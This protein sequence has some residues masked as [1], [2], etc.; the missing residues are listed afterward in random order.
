LAILFA[1]YNIYF[2]G[3]WGQT[4]GKMAMK[5]RVVT[6]AGQPAG[7]TRAL[8][9][10][11]VDLVFSIIQTALSFSEYLSVTSVEYDMLDFRG[12]MLLVHQHEHPATSTIE[13][14]NGLWITSELI[15]LLFNEKRRALHDFLGGT[16]VIHTE[17]KH[18]AA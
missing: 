4:V 16:V 10:H 14:L 6:V 2:I 1:S 3:R 18:V 11:S 7:F 9:R 5:I 17:A 8:Y 12:K 13:A 15:V